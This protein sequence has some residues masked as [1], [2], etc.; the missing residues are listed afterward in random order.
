MEM[1]VVSTGQWVKVGDIDGLVLAVS[2]DGLEVG[3]YQNKIKTIKESVVWRDGQW[4]FKY[5]GP[6]GSYLR[7]EEEDKV[8]R[9][10]RG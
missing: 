2:A 4:C 9:G 3:Y 7:G 8:K 5:S 10:P 6:C 1:P